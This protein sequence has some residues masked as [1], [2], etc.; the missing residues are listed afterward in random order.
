MASDF[1]DRRNSDS[2]AAQARAAQDIARAL[3]RIASALEASAKK[4]VGDEA[5]VQGT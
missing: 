3:E 4:E 5:R 2:A 1:Y